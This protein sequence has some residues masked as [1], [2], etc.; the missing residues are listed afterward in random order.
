MGQTQIRGAQILDHDI[1]FDDLA[2]GS[3]RG[4]TA[5][6]GVQREIATGTV[7]DV[8]IRSAAITPL[9]IDS[10]QGFSMASLTLLN[11]SNQLVL[12]TGTTITLSAPTPSA[13]RVY[14][15]PDTGGT[16]SFVMTESSQTIN[17]TKVFADLRTATNTGIQL[18]NGGGGTAYVDFYGPA[19]GQYRI[20]LSGSAIAFNVAANGTLNVG[21]SSLQISP[22]S[23]P[24]WTF[25]SGGLT[26]STGQIYIA[27]GS[28]GAPSHSFNGDS[29][30]GMFEVGANTIGFATGGQEAVRIDGSQNVGIGGTPL[31]SGLLTLTST[32][33]ALIL[34]RMTTTQRDAISSPTGGMTIY[35]NVTNELNVYNGSTWI[36]VGSTAFPLHGPDGS[37]SA[38][39]YSFSGDTQSGMYRDGSG[40]LAFTFQGSEA[41]RFQTS[42][43]F[44]LL[45]PW[46]LNIEK[47]GGVNDPSIFMG[48][49]N[50]SG[51]WAESSGGGTPHDD[52]IVFGG[53]ADG[54]TFIHKRFSI[55]PT[56]ITQVP[57]DFNQ[58]EARQLVV[59][60]LASDPGSPVEGQI[61]YNTT[62]KQWAGY[63]GTTNVIL[64]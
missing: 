32:S 9:K 10:T 34:P 3:V 14:T 62:T 55:G 11:T 33:K 40:Y 64:G 58:Q 60:V 54:D 52:T 27:L 56:V 36:P 57:I 37:V 17:G 7:S 35:N 51:I 5:N 28:A 44:V 8:D 13:S 42:N 53:G 12:G 61:W 47:L 41:I 19:S 15:I 22:F 50:A 6:G 45:A 43:N 24:S 4:A 30:T 38:P 29:D 20:G 39:S 31:T 1:T 48:G 59:H 16:A 63:N 49:D 23:S 26:S 25:N 46:A 18:N 2:D 21:N